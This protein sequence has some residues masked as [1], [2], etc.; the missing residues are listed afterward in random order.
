MTL[1]RSVTRSK[2]PIRPCTVALAGAWCASLAFAHGGQYRGPGEVIPPSSNSSGGGAAGPASP[3]A[4]SGGGSSA[5]GGTGGSTSTLGGVGASASGGARSAT[6]AG[7]GIPVGPDLSRWQFWWEFNKDES[8]GLRESIQRNRTAPGSDD[9][10][11]GKG[12]GIVD[13]ERPTRAE[14]L[15]SIVPALERSLE[16]AQQRDIV[17]GSMMAMAKIGA[18]RPSTFLRRLKSADQEIRETAALCLGLNGDPDALEDL[19]ALILDTPRGRKL[20]DRESVD[21]RTRAFATYGLAVLA[22]GQDHAVLRRAHAT[23]LQLI[24]PEAPQNR[25]LRVAALQACRRIGVMTADR[26]IGPMIR[27]DLAKQ[28]EAY[29]VA[30]LGPGEGWLQA[31][32]A[33]TLAACLRRGDDDRHRR[34]LA[35]LEKD[36][37]G[38]RGIALSQ[39]AALAIGGLILD[40]TTHPAHLPHAKRL[41]QAA[42]DADDQQTRYFA[43]IALGSLEWDGARD[44]LVQLLDGGSQLSSTWAAMA[45]GFAARSGSTPEP[46]HLEKVIRG[47]EQARNPETRAGYAVALG[48]LQADD[49]APDLRAQ[50]ERYQHQDDYAGYLAIALSLLEDRAAAPQIRG[51]LEASSRRPELLIQ[52]AV[53]LG[54]LG[55]RHTVT[56]LMDQVLGEGGVAVVGASA[57]ALGRIGDRRSIEPLVALLHDETAQPLSRAFA[58][59]ALGGI[60]DSRE[61]PWNAHFGAGINYRASV[62]TL[63][64]QAMGILDLF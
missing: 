12:A 18:G 48:L 3:G 44:A 1:Q 28:L 25:E 42:R 56:V 7:G 20:V 57:S 34:V 63:T 26:G 9:A 61:I 10:F 30:D 53:A 21:D 31:H 43:T 11:M 16:T 46:A 38:R 22:D 4:T 41:I 27:A 39:S 8:I 5:G 54:R 55:D 59:V 36:L 6:A 47:F 17:S 23:L 32:A 52:C 35:I 60:G 14:I 62:S 51:L 29:L 2:L 13:L 45:L 24:D 15:A 19:D 37:S 50:L 33:T 40:P 64:D 58:A 49:Q